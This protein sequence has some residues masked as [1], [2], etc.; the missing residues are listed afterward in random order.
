MPRTKENS[1]RK[2]DK[3]SM[4]LSRLENDI[5]DLQSESRI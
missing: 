2:T 4:N 3:I 5:R 1:G